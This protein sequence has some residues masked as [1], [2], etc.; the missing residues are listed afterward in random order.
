MPPVFEERNFEFRDGRAPEHVDQSPSGSKRDLGKFAL[1][2]EHVGSSHFQAL[3]TDVDC[4]PVART[5][6][7]AYQ[8][9]DAKLDKLPSEKTIIHILLPQA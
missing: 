8:T 9:L 3:A 4:L 1:V 6:A 2:V 7:E 5:L